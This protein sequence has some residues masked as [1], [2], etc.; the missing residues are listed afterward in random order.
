MF[1]L[2]S[3]NYDSYALIDGVRTLLDESCSPQ[4]NVQQY[5]IKKVP[6]DQAILFFFPCHSI[7]LFV[8]LSI[9]TSK[10]S[11]VSMND[12]G[13]GDRGKHRDCINLLK[14]KTYSK[15]M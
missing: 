6:Y 10:V 13:L 7:H 15:C 4:Q 5:N 12:Q 1:N 3:T 8:M 2:D 9:M 14:C 11:I